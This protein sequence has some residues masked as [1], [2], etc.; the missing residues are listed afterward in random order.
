MILGEEYRWN[1]PVITYGFD[2]EFLAYFGEEGVAAVERAIAI[3]SNL[4][5]VSEINLDDYDTRSVLV[6][7]DAV[8]LGLLD[9]KS[10]TLQWLMYQLGLAQASRYVWT[11]RERTNE[12]TNVVQRNYN[13]A[14]LLPSDLVNDIRYGY[15]IIAFADGSADAIETLDPLATFAFS[16]VTDAHLSAGRFLVGLTRDD[17]GGLRYLYSRTNINIETFPGSMEAT[18]RPGIEE[19]NFVKMSWD[20]N[21][22]RFN[23]VTSSFDITFVTNGL[24]Q[25]QH[26]QRVVTTPDILFEMRDLGGFRERGPAGEYYFLLRLTEGSDTAHW[27]NLSSMNAGTDGPG[28]IVPGARLTFNKLGKYAG[29]GG[30][31]SYQWGSFDETSNPPV[32]FTGNERAQTVTLD[33]YLE[34]EGTNSY[35]TS[36]L[37]GT[38]GA[39]YQVD[40]STNLSDW[41]PFTTVTNENWMYGHFSFRDEVRDSR[42]FYRAVRRD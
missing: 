25:T 42:K 24:T 13:P 10:V 41:T 29:L 19:F 5:P 32:I 1:L 26:V 31:S 7:Q 4:P 11:I 8:A 20:T 17:G 23:S 33:N 27:Q 9:V 14:T 40:S 22:Q 38:V 35:F 30:L 3:L 16:A 28:I 39:V 18:A 15:Q 21:G 6:N 34:K 2:G 12:S 37:L 36:V